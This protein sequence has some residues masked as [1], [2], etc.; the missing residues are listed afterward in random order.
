MV[1]YRMVDGYTLLASIYQYTFR[2]ADYKAL[3]TNSI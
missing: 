2:M 1:Y 3:D